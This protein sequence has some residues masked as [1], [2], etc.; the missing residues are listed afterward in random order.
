MFHP[1]RYM[2]DRIVT[3]G[4]LTLIDA[5]GRSHDFGDQR[6]TH[7]VAR[8]PDK[9]TER[10]LALHPTLA[11]GEAYM[12]GGLT[13]EQGTVYDFIDLLAANLQDKTF[14]RWFSAAER[15]R[16]LTRRLWQINPRSVAKQN[17]AHHYDLDGRLYDL[18]LD[19]DRQ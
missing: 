1:L 4:H 13:I 12:D 3:S 16:F 8:L 15:L 19:E 17:V 18:F 5:E 7:V 10:R 14:P 11:L 6:G 9:R 2:L